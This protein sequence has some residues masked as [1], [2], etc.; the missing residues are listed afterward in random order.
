MG[1]TLQWDHAVESA[2]HLRFEY[3]WSWP[4]VDGVTDDVLKRLN[5]ASEPVSLIIDMTTSGTPPQGLLLRTPPLLSS[6]HPNLKQFVFVA[7]TFSRNLLTLLKNL[8]TVNPVEFTLAGSLDDA[9]TL[10]NHHLMYY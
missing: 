7:D 9:R 5:E 2:L 10:C 3:P 1:I 6:H 4:D 8:H